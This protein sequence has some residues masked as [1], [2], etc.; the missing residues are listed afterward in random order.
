MILE[1]RPD[2]KDARNLLKE[3]EREKEETK[4][5]VTKQDERK[6]EELYDQGVALYREEKLQEAVR[7]WQKAVEINPEFVEARVFLSKAETKIRNLEKYA[8]AKS[9]KQGSKKEL[10]EDLRIKVKKHYLDGINY[11][12]AGLYK[13]AISEWEEVLKIDPDYENVRINI[14]RAKNR[15][16][17]ETDQG[18]S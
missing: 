4:V 15:L 13:E 14:E 12:M 8:S 6:A 2:Y 11:Y 9:D 17:F 10:S 7:V 16:G 5:V 1:V 3:M 18:S